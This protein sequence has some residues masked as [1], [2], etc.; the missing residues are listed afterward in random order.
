MQTSFNDFIER[1]TSGR[2]T[3]RRSGS[4]GFKVQ[5]SQSRKRTGEDGPP[6]GI[7]NTSGRFLSSNINLITIVLFVIVYLAFPTRNS[8][9]DAYYYAAS[10]KY[11]GELFHPHHLLYNITGYMVLKAVRG[12]GLHPDVLA[13]MKVLNSLLAGLSLVILSKIL[14]RMNRTKGEITGL[15][16]IA[17][18]AFAIWRFATENETYLFPLVLSLAGSLKFIDFQDGKRN[19]N[20]VL[21]GSFCALAVLYHQIHIFWWLGLLFGTAY[22]TRK[23]GVILSYGFTALFIPLI[24]LV[25]FY[26]LPS[27]Y[28]EGSFTR[29]VFREYYLGGVETGIGWPNFYLTV[30]NFIRSFFQVHGI[31]FIMIRKNILF[32]LPG[33]MVFVLLV[34]G[35]IKSEITP[36]ERRITDRIFIN[37][38]ILIFVLQLIFAFYSV[39]NAEFMVMLPVL[40]LII[41]AGL[42]EIKTIALV[43]FGAGLFI[44]NLSFGILPA[45]QVDFTHHTVLVPRIL[46]NEQDLFI[47]KSD[48][49]VLSKI[50]YETGRE[51]HRNIQKAPEN[52]LRRKLPLAILEERIEKNLTSGNRVFT[53]CINRPAIISRATMLD[54]GMD[55]EFFRRYTH[56]A[57]DSVSTFTGVYYLF[58]IKGMKGE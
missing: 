20:L 26:S 56:V 46:S 8:S 18:S 7:K 43:C 25:V 45:W 2:G 34:T 23:P 3:P 54:R 17:G 36:R 57:V 5:N 42:F 16:L 15:L 53:D 30:I 33:I 49:H 28:S 31:M 29:F 51:D 14:R 40:S 22:Y 58:E 38:H 12:I 35:I 41:L 47:L 48:Q 10:I 6:Y 1:E 44:W 55:E 9:T 13:L 21:S 39:G 11:Q 27:G 4:S 50:Y 19:V 37:S 52:L 24:Y 32:I